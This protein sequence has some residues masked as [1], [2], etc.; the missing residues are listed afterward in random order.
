MTT[1]IVYHTKSDGLG[2]CHFTLFW[3][4]NYHPGHPDGEYR[5]AERGQCFYANPE[6]Y[7][8]KKLEDRGEA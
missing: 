5:H 4:A 1:R 3:Y 7:G 6:D 2:K 8:F